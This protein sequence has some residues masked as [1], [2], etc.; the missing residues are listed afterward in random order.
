MALLVLVAWA[1][2]ATACAESGDTVST[3]GD[4][5]GGATACNFDTECL[6]GQTCSNGFCVDSD[7]DTDGDLPDGDSADGDMIVDGDKPDGDGPIIRCP[8]VLDFGAAQVNVPT[9]RQLE[10]ANEG[11]MTLEIRAMEFALQTTEFSINYTPDSTVTIPPGVSITFDVT[12]EPARGYE[13][14]MPLQ[15]ASNAKN[16]ALCTV[17]LQSEYKGE[18]TI[19]FDPEEVLFGNVRVDDPGMD[20]EL[21]ICN[22]GTGNKAIKISGLGF[23]YPSSAAHFRFDLDEETPTNS[24]PIFLNT[25]S[26]LP[27]QLTYDPTESTTW[28]EMHE[29]YLVVYNDADNS[30]NNQS[31][32]FLSGS[33]DQFS[34]RV[35]P[36]PI[37]FG[38]VVVE[39]TGSINLTIEN[40]SGAPVTVTDIRLSGNHCYEFQL[41][42]GDH[43]TFPFE[44][45]IE[46]MITDIGV[47]YTPTNTGPDQGCYL[48]ITYDQ[49]ERTKYSKT[50]LNGSGRLENEKPIAKVSRTDNGSD[51]S[52]PIDIPPTASSVQKRITLYGDISSDP[53]GNYPLTY[54]WAFEKPG[55]SNAEIW[56]SLTDSTI[57]F[58]V[59]WA[60]PYTLTLVVTD[61]EGAV[62][63]PKQ[64]FVN[65]GT[66]QKVTID[67]E[68][69]GSG[70]MNVN[71]A[72]ITPNGMRCS[73]ETMT[74]QRTCLLGPD[75]NAFVS[76]Y[77]S[78]AEDGQRETI[79]H[80]NAPD[81]AY[82]V[83]V[84]FA[85]DCA[86][87]DIGFF[88]L[89]RRSS[90]VTVRIYVDMETEARYTM[91][92][93]L[94]E[95]G[96]IKQWFIN[97]VGGEWN[98]PTTN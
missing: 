28:P 90:D 62:S 41:Y 91:T 70:A 36:N 34:L 86:G 92:T 81:G 38:Q 56:P 10:I 42:L 89:D 50:S 22:E 49:S 14:N 64:V 20:I 23:K 58:T 52:M 16:E 95:K 5:D 69:S 72:W 27:V 60:G 19:V 59:D 24:D 37:N 39:E 68:F 75:G 47:G 45:A 1:V 54:E 63:D 44:M 13:A 21:H 48:L 26:C 6:I 55:E 51:I 76:N 9:V 67:M 31:D 30:T 88:C 12:F 46:D 61:S 11:D 43:G 33:A 96:N 3:D 57:T 65:M 93:H 40:Q 85:E 84:S 87:W 32:V 4:A 94:S 8:D 73:D 74:S 77:T 97:K 17:L 53:D 80:P 7:G 71:L 83:Q 98:A 78:Q 29:N 2:F 82:T 18:S 79:V 35:E 66:N 15:I 25:G